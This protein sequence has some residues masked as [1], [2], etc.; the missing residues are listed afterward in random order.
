[1]SWPLERLDNAR[2]VEPPW[3]NMCLEYEQFR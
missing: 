2:R 3:A 1:M